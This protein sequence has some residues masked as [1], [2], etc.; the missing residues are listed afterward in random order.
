MSF[1]IDIEIILST[2]LKVIRSKDI[3]LEKLVT[4]SKFTGNVVI[5]EGASITKGV[6]SG[7]I[8]KVQIMRC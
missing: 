6:G 4:T 7:V 8:K 2:I 3:N 1:S 5:A